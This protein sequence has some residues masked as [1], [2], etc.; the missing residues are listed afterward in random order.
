MKNS[1][2]R[3]VLACLVVLIPAAFGQQTAKSLFNL[4]R[5]RMCKTPLLTVTAD[6][7]R[8]RRAIR[9]AQWPTPIKPLN[10]I[11]KLPQPARVEGVASQLLVSQSLQFARQRMC[12]Y[13]WGFID[14]IRMVHKI[15][16]QVDGVMEKL[17][18]DQL[19]AIT[20]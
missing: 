12:L 1:A 9:R 19:F 18:A 10:S 14:S 2:P 16:D 6:W 11:Q 15:D 4:T 8:K 3:M 17:T 13:H 20:T 7:P 5:K